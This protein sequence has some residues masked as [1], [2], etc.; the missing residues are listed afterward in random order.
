MRRFAYGG[1]R[2]IFCL[3]RNQSCQVREELQIGIER[4]NF[5][6]L[7]DGGGGQIRVAEI[8]IREG[9]ASER[10]EDAFAVFRFE[11]VGLD[12]RDESDRSFDAGM[13]VDSGEDVEDFRDRHGRDRQPDLA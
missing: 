5:V 13:F 6:T 7:F 11:G 1:G 4:G 8:D 12:E 9:D 10:V 3:L 2:P